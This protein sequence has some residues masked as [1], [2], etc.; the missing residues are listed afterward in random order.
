MKISGVYS[1]SSF[2]KSGRVYIG[3][4][5]SIYD[6]WDNHKSLLKLNKHN[7]LKLQSH[8]NKYWTKI[9]RRT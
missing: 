1:I 3:S 7:N 9:I 2:C 5:V 8:F 6:R 4:S